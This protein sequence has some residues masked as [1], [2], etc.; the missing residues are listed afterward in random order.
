MNVT[1]P[2]KDVVEGITVGIKVTGL[3]KFKTRLKIAAFLISIA[4][5]IGGLNCKVNE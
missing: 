2:I 5:K 3:T 4:C 1:V